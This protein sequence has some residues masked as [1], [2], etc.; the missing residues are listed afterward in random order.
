MSF[1]SFHLC[2]Y[3]LSAQGA[4]P[5]LICSFLIFN[6]W[7]LY[8]IYTNRSFPAHTKT[9]IKH[10]PWIMHTP[11]LISLCTSKCLESIDHL[12]FFPVHL[13]CTPQCFYKYPRK[14][15]A[16]TS[17]TVPSQ[18]DSKTSFLFPSS[19]SFIFEGN[20][21]GR[22][23]WVPLL[24][25]YRQRLYHAELSHIRSYLFV[26]IRESREIISKVVPT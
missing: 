4:Y 12:H 6:L 1:T 13:P 20:T 9:Q 21:T 11:K 10:S 22:P 19:S 26:Q 8:L 5:Y 15:L 14:C 2:Y 17:I 3:L 25:S 7:V 24:V 23:K 18:W 16:G